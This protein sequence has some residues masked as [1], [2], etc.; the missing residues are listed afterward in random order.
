MLSGCHWRRTQP[1]STSQGSASR[2]KCTS[3]WVTRRQ[4]V[5]NAHSLANPWIGAIHHTA[6]ERL[7]VDFFLLILFKRSAS[8]AKLG[9]KRLKPLHNPG[10]ERSSVRLVGALRP[11]IAFVVC[12]ATSMRIGRMT[13]SRLR[14]ASG[15]KPHFLSL[16]VTAALLRSMRTLRT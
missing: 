3:N 1:A 14:M 5:R 13:I 11:P 7:M 16:S 9:S 4:T 8:L 10:I 6:F 12:N 2:I 15:E